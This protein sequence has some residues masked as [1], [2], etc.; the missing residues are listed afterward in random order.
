MDNK[1][2]CKK[3]LKSNIQ[4]NCKTELVITFTRIGLFVVKY[5][6]KFIKIICKIKDFLY[7]KPESFHLTQEHD[8]GMSSLLKK[9]SDS[10]AWT[11]GWGTCHS[12]DCFQ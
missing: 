4:F 11:D 5:I 12:K 10:L 8:S 2:Q 6:D 7:R 3:R 1:D 9:M